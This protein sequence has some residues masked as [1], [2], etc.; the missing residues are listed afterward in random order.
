MNHLYKC[1]TALFPVRLVYTAFMAVVVLYSQTAKSAPIIV[2]DSIASINISRS[3]EYLEDRNGTLGIDQVMKITDAGEW[4]ANTRDYVGFGYTRSAYWFK[5]TLSNSRTSP[6]RLL[7]EIDFPSLDF[8]DLYFPADRGGYG[9]LKTG[10]RLSFSTREI[11]DRNFIFPLN[12][13][14]GDGTYYLRISNGGSLRFRARVFSDRALLENRGLSLPLLGCLYGMILLTSLFYF[15]LY[16]FLRD[17]VYIYFS[18]FTLNIIIYQ[19]SLMGFAFQYLWPEWPWWANT[20][21][22]VLMNVIG[23][24]SALFLRKILDTRATNAFLHRLFSFFGLAAFPALTVLS[25]L[26]PFN[27]IVPVTYYAFFAYGVLVIPSTVYYIMRGN[28]FASYFLVGGV[29]L[30]VTNI[31]SS[32]TALG[33]L[34]ST[35]FTEGSMELGYFLLVLFSSLGLV[36]R[37]YIMTRDLKDSQFSVK[38]KNEMLTRTNEEL[39][40]TNEEL[41]AMNEEF[42][43]QN[44]GLLESERALSASEVEMKEIFNSSHD[45]FIIHDR[46][47]RILDVNRRMLDMY[48]MTRE[49]ALSMS[50]A[51]ISSPDTDP[52]LGCRYMQRV[53]AG[54]ELLFE[55]KAFRPGNKSAFDVEVGLKKLSWRGREV[56][57]ASVRDLTDRT[58][59]EAERERVRG[60]LVQAQKME[61][62]GTLAGGIAHDFN[63]VLGG[64]M[65]SLNLVDLMLKKE[66]LENTEDIFKY[67]ETATDSSRRAAD[68]T[69]QLLT[70][71]RKRELQKSAVIVQN[72]LK[73][74]LNICKNSFPKS[75]DLDF[76]CGGEP[77]TVHADPT[78]IEQALLN[79]CVNASHA[80]TLMRGEGTRH[81]GRLTVEALPVSS[82]H[83]FCA[84]HPGAIEGAS[85]VLIRVED[86]GVGMDE[87]IQCRIFDPFYTTKS[88]DEGTGLGL[89]ITYSIVK[90]H[91]GFIDVESKPGQGS[92]F[93]IYLPLM[94]EA[95][96]GLPDRAH[97]IVRG[98]GRILVVDDE[99]TILR[100]AM[101]MLE[102]CGYEVITAGSAEQGIRVFAR[103]HAGIR[104]VVLDTAM[105]GK[106]GLEV[107]E[108]MKGIDPGVRVLLCSGFMDASTMEKARE[109]G[110]RVFI[111]KP[112]SLEELS[113]KLNDATG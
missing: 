80:M 24:F 40:A 61:A 55:W 108:A 107:Y 13:A 34:P 58:N 83:E 79:L 3:I 7:L 111:N 69:R 103:E 105:P 98:A 38:E 39:T 32:L 21:I 78:Q 6:G 8:I 14:P 51:Y 26:L 70:L 100:V 27:I 112:Y 109:M 35:Q 46:D 91:G 94:E 42:E 104:A 87:E 73:N 56:I 19:I 41:E 84:L 22:P 16:V 76:R 97:G 54:E 67:L 47:G 36:D 57:L 2:D 25:P 96:A 59:A 11:K 71:S 86:T 113:R 37:F 85:C 9:V 101:A 49:E 75:V 102:Q 68:M 92:V 17:R 23:I 43:A 81:G 30:A 62:V 10:D 28:R 110:V 106:S 45:A 88:Q 77:L 66:R 64:I 31:I 18:I 52:A 1:A 60:Q 20:V 93:K 99:E 72:S 65:G 63:N 12:P 95:R 33:R 82:D 53:I 4:K 29:V 15:F 89:A 50:M 48:G 90:L 5:F 44:R 74:V